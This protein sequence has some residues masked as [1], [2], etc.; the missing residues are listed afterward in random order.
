MRPLSTCIIVN[1]IDLDFYFD[2]I[3][4]Y[5]SSP[6]IKIYTNV[7]KFNISTAIY[8]FIIYSYIYAHTSL[9]FQ[10]FIQIEKPELINNVTK[11]FLSANIPLYKLRNKELCELFNFLGCAPPSETSCRN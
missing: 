5:K 1:K 6:Y 2:Y 4:V 3:Y 10:T 8:I 11:A 9:C 7:L